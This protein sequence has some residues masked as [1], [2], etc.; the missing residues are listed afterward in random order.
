MNKKAI[1][2]TVR[3]GS[4]RLPNKALLEINGKTT[5]EHL[6]SRVKKSEKAD[7]IILCTTTLEN[8]NILC[9]IA[10]RNEILPR[11]RERQARTMERSLQEV[12]Y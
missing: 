5:I 4:S 7:A 6:I 11:Q 8:D 12:W 10:E 3:T 9:E 2:I 1:F